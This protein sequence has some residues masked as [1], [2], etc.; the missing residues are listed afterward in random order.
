MDTL[1]AIGAASADQATR[2]LSFDNAEL[3]GEDFL[4]LMIEE[5]VHQDPLDPIKNDQLLAQVSQMKNME[6][7][8][9]LDKTLSGMIYQQKVATGGALI[10]KVVSGI[11]NSGENVSGEVVRVI[12][13]GAGG[14]T[15]ITAGGDEISMDLVTAIEEGLQDG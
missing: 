6:T 15:V 11:S 13:S 14:V 4:R 9:N 7:L 2:S 10:G 12:A 8:S 5:L 3:T 1:A